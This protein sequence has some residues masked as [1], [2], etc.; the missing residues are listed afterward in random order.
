MFK[1]NSPINFNGFNDSSRPKGLNLTV[2]NEISLAVLAENRFLNIFLIA[3]GIPAIVTNLFVILCII[4]GQKLH[5]RCYL[6]IANL[7]LADL[8]CGIEGISGGAKRLARHLTGTPETNT[9]VNCLLELLLQIFSY[10]ASIS[11]TLTITIDRFIAV[12]FPVVYKM[13]LGTTYIALM[14]LVFWLDAAVVTAAFF[15]DVQYQQ[16]VP[17]CDMPYVMNPVIM[18]VVQ[19]KTLAMNN[20]G[21]DLY[22]IRDQS[23]NT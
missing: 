19:H 20:T 15:I 5:N 14:L 18:K 23:N 1:N 16:T 10:R 22:T 4:K 17:V 12:C 13:K 8:L 7:A 21:I 3:S 11:F 2:L 9:A 6:F